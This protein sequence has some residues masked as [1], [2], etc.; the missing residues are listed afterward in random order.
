[1]SIFNFLFGW[2]GDDSI[3]EPDD[4]LTSQH[5]DT[6]CS[7]NPATGLPMLDSDAC[8]GVDVGGNPYGT[9]LHDGWSSNGLFDDPWSL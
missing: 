5:A 4:D 6:G 9:D 1:M 7:V 2:L 3:A 8:G